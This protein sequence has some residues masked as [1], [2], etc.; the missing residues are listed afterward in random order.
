MKQS[1]QPPLAGC[2]SEAERR[3]RLGQYFT[4]A[5]LGRVLA[6]LAQAEKAESIVDPMA[7]TGDLLAACLEIGAAPAS[8]AGIEIDRVARDACANRLPQADC[9]KP[10]VFWAALLTQILSHACERRTGTW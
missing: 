2:A 6:A 3:K 9:R 7:G 1:H 8:I 5:G 10:I 4:G